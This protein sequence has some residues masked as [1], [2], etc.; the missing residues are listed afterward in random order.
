RDAQLTG[1]N[2]LMVDDEPDARAL[3]KR[4]LE[5]RGAKVRLAGSAAEAMDKMREET[6][7]VLLSDIGMPIEDGY[8]LIRKVRALKPSEGGS[9]PAIAL[10]AY[11]RAEDQMKTM[12]AGFQMHV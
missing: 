6:P 3:I 11:A 2:V 9:V 7:D 10:T 4:F 8:V 1:L 5:D 12:L